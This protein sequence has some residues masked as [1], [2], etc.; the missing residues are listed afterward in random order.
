SANVLYSTNQSTSMAGYMETPKFFGMSS[1]EGMGTMLPFILGSQ[2]ASFRNKAA[3]E[4][5]VSK[6]SSLN[7]RFIQTYLQTLTIKINVEPAKNFKIQLDC[8]ATKSSTYSER[9]HVQTSGSD[10]FESTG[11]TRSG[12]YAITTISILTAFDK[13]VPGS[14]DPN[15]SVTFEKFGQYRSVMLDR[16]GGGTGYDQNSQD[17]L[18]PAFLAAYTGTNPNTSNLKGIPNI[19]LPNWRI[20]YSGLGQLAFLKKSFKS[21]TMSHAY[22]SQYMVG[23]FSSS[24]LYNSSYIVPG[25]N[26]FTTPKMADSI[27]AS[28]QI[29]PI[30]IISGVS[31]KEEFAPMIGI[32]ASTNN[33]ITYRLLYSRTRTLNLSTSNAQITENITNSI[34][35]GLGFARSNVA[36]PKFLTNGK[37]V[38]L[39][40]ELNMNVNF[41]IND[42][43]SYQRRFAENTTITA[44]NTNVQFKPT[45]SYNL[46]QRVTLQF[47]FER[48]I[49]SPKISSSFRRATTAFGIQLRF[50]LS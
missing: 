24:M 38:L 50:T 4:G 27:N 1:T 20:D 44:G 30:Y 18:I 48:T 32:N 5:W 47:Y 35:V 10:D 43:V 17:V 42:M 34:T 13:H 21:I 14:S 12:G 23:S 28:G 33:K 19:P 37:K 8:K 31:I 2:D 26:F 15:S 6:A 29:V 9:F 49:N 25:T 45:I 41:T 11:P 39:K 3:Q 36:I 40:N 7:D 22:L 46:S 16:L